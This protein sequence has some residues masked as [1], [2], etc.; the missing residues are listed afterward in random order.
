MIRY[1]FLPIFQDGQA[2]ITVFDAQTGQDVVLSE[3]DIEA[4]KR[5]YNGKVPDGDYDLYAD[6]VP[7]FSSQVQ[8]TRGNQITWFRK[9]V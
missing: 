5:V 9:H 7:W 8:P 3:K 6:H 2:G 1:N 4:V